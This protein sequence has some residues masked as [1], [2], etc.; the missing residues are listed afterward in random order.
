MELLVN[1]VTFRYPSIA[2]I[3]PLM[4]GAVMGRY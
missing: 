2:A 4:F 1:G 3:M